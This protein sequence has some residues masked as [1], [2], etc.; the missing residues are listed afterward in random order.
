MKWFE[1]YILFVLFGDFIYR[2]QVRQYQTD[3]CCWYDR[4]KQRMSK[5]DPDVSPFQ[6]YYGI[7]RI[8]K[9]LYLNVRLRDWFRPCWQHPEA[10]VFWYSFGPFTLILNPW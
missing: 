5:N 6:Q 2:T 8:F 3:I 10:D 7:R 9:G 4:W 1:H